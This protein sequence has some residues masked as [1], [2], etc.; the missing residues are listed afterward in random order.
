MAGSRL[1]EILALTI[2]RKDALLCGCCGG[3]HVETVQELSGVQRAC[4]CTCCHGPWFESFE[5][6]FPD[7]IITRGRDR[8]ITQAAL[9][10]A[11]RR[12]EAEIASREN[13]GT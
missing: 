10:E 6:D 3:H 4:S 7:L 8:V 11:I 12:M 5:A 13:G 2:E 1:S 9:E